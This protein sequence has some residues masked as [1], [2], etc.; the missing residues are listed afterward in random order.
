MG[1]ENLVSVQGQDEVQTL[2]LNGA[3]SGQFTLTLVLNM[4]GAPAPQEG[5]TQVAPTNAYTGLYAPQNSQLLDIG[6]LFAQGTQ[7]AATLQS[8]LES[9]P[10]VGAGNVSVS[11]SAAAGFTIVFINQLS[12]GTIPL[13]LV[14][15]LSGINPAPTV[16]EATQG[17]G[18]LKISSPISSNSASSTRKERKGTLKLAGD[19]QAGNFQGNLTVDDGLLEA[20]NAD[21]LSSGVAPNSFTPTVSASGNV[22][23]GAVGLTGSATYAAATNTWT[24]SGSGSDIWGGTDQCHYVY[25]TVSATTPAIWIANIASVAGGDGTWTKVGITVRASTAVNAP[26]IDLFETSGS[27][28]TSQWSIVNGQS[29]GQNSANHGT[30]SPAWLEIVYDGLGDFSLYYNNSPVTSGVP[31]AWTF[32]QTITPATIAAYPMPTSGSFDVGLEITAHNNAALATAVF[33]YNNFLNNFAVAGTPNTS[34]TVNSGAGLVYNLP[35]TVTALSTPISLAGT[36]YLNS[37]YSPNSADPSGTLRSIGAGALTYAG[38]ITNST[39]EAVVYTAPGTTFIDNGAITS[40]AAGEPFIKTGTGTLVLGG[41]S[42]FAGG[43]NLYVDLGTVLLNLP[44]TN[45][46]NTHVV[47]GTNDGGPGAARILY[48]ST[49]GTTQIVAAGNITINRSGLLDLN[50]MSQTSASLTIVDGSVIDSGSGG[51]LTTTG[52]S[53]MTGGLV[54]TGAPTASIV[55]NGATESGSTVT[56]TTSIPLALLVGET[57]TISGVGWATPNGGYNG[58]FTVA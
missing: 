26:Q 9:I 45:N 13:L 2:N 51:M 40:P 7:A 55:A 35:G 8:A 32:I 57:I 58:A 39:N 52:A 53:S 28:V 25:T 5:T 44:G 56:I 54:N 48:A 21:A 43:Q 37:N 41:S 50:G 38:T 1:T 20:D 34:V 24:V 22:D 49:A 23:I 10:A 18:A 14:N 4:P 3:T 12:G 19:N 15:N 11:G 6:T 29:P 36:G 42:K 47:I 31:T 30:A 16:A 17:G 46:L 33:P 27:Q